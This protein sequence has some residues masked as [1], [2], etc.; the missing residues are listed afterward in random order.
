MSIRYDMLV[1][2]LDGTLLTPGGIVTP[3][4]VRAVQ[5]AREAGIEIVIATGRALVESLDPLAAIG[6]EGL[7]VAAGGSL[8]CDAAT[9]RTVDRSAMPHDLVVDV[10]AS[11]LRHGHKALLLKDA[12][13][14]GYDYLAVGP[15]ELDPA[16]QWWFETLPVRVRFVHE[17]DDDPHPADTVRAGAVASEEELAPLAEWLAEEI[18]DRGFLQHWG[19]VTETE[20]IGATTHLL[21]VFNPHVS[22]WTMIQRICR[23]KGIDRRRVAAIGDGLNDVQ[24]V[25]E[26]A[27]GVA[28]GNADPR[29]RAV[30]D[31]MTDDYESDGA[32]K[33]IDK[34]IAGRW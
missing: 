4:S 9:G 13:R 31:R 20:V 26:A 7:V 25:C 22:K 12:D 21:E 3:A 5:R 28:M 18:G 17:I 1:I 23:D 2:D 8:L 16:S 11:L 32:A 15:G 34:I 14:A 10:V 24:I 6:H 19:A 29:V 30:A 27:L 33:A